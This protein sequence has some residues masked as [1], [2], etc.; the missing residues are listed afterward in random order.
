MRRDVA[1]DK[2]SR[3]KIGD[4]E[5]SL[6]TCT[7]TQGE[8]EVKV[9]PRSMDVLNYLAEH[10][11]EVVSHD[12]LLNH[13]WH[14]SF[15]SDHAVH[16]AIAELRGALGD[17]A[18]HPIYIRTIPKRGY[19]LIAEVQHCTSLTQR[20]ES[21]EAQPLGITH[22]SSLKFHLNALLDKRILAGGA[23]AAIF[24]SVLMWPGTQVSSDKDEVVRLA[25]L[26]FVNRELSTENQF[27]T[28][29][30][31]ESLVHGL[32][33]LSHLEVLSPA[34][35]FDGPDD[36]RTAE[37]ATD[38]AKALRADHV[39]Q[40]SVQVAEGRM[41]V[42]VQLIRASDG[43]HQYSDQFDLPIQ[44]LFGVQD[45]IVSNV[46]SALS[47]HLN[48]A[49]REQ[50]LDWGTTDALAYERFLRGEFY[51]NQFSPDDFQRAID[52][53]LSAIELDPDFLNAYHG[54]ATAANNLAVYS[55][56][57]KINE[58]SKLISDIHREVSRLA[59]DST[60]L[61]SINEIKLRMSGNNQ[62][63]QEMQLREQI[64]SGNPPEFAVAHYA[65]FLIGARLYDE[66]A[67]FLD[68]AGEVGPFEISP[69][70]VWSYR[71]NIQPPR[72][73]L[74]SAKGQLQERPYH[75]SFL[76]TVATNLALAGD[77]RQAEMYLNRQRDVD[78]E[79]ILAH[80]SEAIIGFLSGEI[81]LGNKAHHEIMSREG[82][83]AFNK[84]ALS[85]MLGDIETGIELWRSL[86]PPQKRRLFN[87][88]H[89]AEKYFPQSV[90]ED[91]RY[92]ALLE[93]LG[94]GKSWQRQLMEGVMAMEAVT[95]VSLNE[96]SRQ[97]YES[98]TFM[99]RNNLW[100]AEDW[101]ELESTKLAD[102]QATLIP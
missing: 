32:S 98:N 61:S 27:L 69:D 54:A 23:A 75:I 42:M 87:V 73:M 79:G 84:G 48:E 101:S 55:S 35:G 56:A 9:T 43:V 66:A 64:L 10:A 76:G 49:E 11:G 91:P 47:V 4:W 62:I 8:Q 63:Q 12:E 14:G 85:F 31:R 1:T 88:T 95:G 22:V 36:S 83:F 13:F 97:A 78:N 100:T 41:R 24:L 44:D 94:L 20:E 34:R 15:P 99:S 68:A 82:D 30:L 3:I 25:V 80:Y 90:L 39:L 37:R 5:V 65:L 96:K 81:V 52:Y 92:Q 70:E 28:D 7:L 40:G 18:H 26:P 59:P 89:S 51:Y 67:Q 102:L 58:L 17:D 2:L 57:E 38:R 53:H 93:E 74:L 16:K 6:T 50:M 29:G 19:S 86:T 71:S 46:V 21:E 72:A 60:V 33:K 77:F 45:Q